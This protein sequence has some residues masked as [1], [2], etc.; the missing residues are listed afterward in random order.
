ML[1]LATA[2]NYGA[3]NKGGDKVP[4]CPELVIIHTYHTQLNPGN[5]IPSGFHSIRV[6]QKATQVL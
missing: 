3:L 4:F 6:L 2:Q 1:S 5:R